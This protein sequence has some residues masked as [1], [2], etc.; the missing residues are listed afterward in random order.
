M[1]GKITS[2]NSIYGVLNY[3]HIKVENDKGKVILSN[4][5]FERDAG[6]LDIYDCM[7]SF[8]PYLC[9]NERIKKPII[10]ISLNPHP[11]DILSEEQLSKIASEYMEQMGYGNQPYVVYQHNDIDRSHLH[12]VSVRVNENGEKIDHNFEAR[13]SLEILQGIEKKYNLHPA[14]KGEELKD[15]LTISK[16]DYRR[17]DVK[18]QVGSVVRALKS[19][20][21]FHTL[22]EFNALLNLYNVSVEEIK[23][24]ANG[25]TYHGLMYHP[26]DGNGNRIGT[27]FKSSKIGKDVGMTALQK[28][29]TAK[30]ND[31][32]KESLI[33]KIKDV[34][35]INR[36]EF[37]AKLRQE[38]IAVVFREN[39]A[40][41]I[42]GVTFI[43]H[44]TQS[45]FNGSRL[46]K[47]FSANM[48]N[49]LFHSQE[50][51][52]Y[53]QHNMPN[54]IEETIDGGTDLFYSLLYNGTI[55]HPEDEQHLRK[56]KR[57][58][59]R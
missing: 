24:E 15:R 58:I 30:N 48:F 9:L 47:E 31:V 39:D 28:K 26:M 46:G 12:I 56:R 34:K 40:G 54:F 55:E 16:V 23:G 17:G 25:K 44:D 5:V 13:K 11:K 8:E 14:V 33:K 19:Q 36:K 37:T 6:K 20:Y 49:D 45:V 42:Y 1:V 4:R 2:G 29:Y 51:F 22:G 10:H 50:H 27:P 53:I 52:E 32:G 3:N 35:T 59:K 41:R 57:K 7:K 18:C 38:N 21:K 43:D